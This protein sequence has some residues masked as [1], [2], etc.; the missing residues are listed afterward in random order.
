MI[1]PRH[2]GEPFFAEVGDFLGESY[3]R[4]A[5]TKGTE[6][7][8]G[9]LIDLLELPD[10]ARVLDVGCGPG[11]H[12]LALARRGLQVTGVDISPRFLEL[13]RDRANELGLA[14]RIALFD[15]D[16]RT[17]PFESEFDAVIAVCEGAFGLMG[18]DDALV[19]RRMME[20]AKPGGRVVLTAINAYADVLLNRPEA[21]LD[22]DLGVMHERTVVTSP[23]GERKEVDLWTSVYT[24]RELRLMAIGVGLDPEHVWGVDPGDFDRRAP[25]V[26]RAELMLVA[27]RPIERRSA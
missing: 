1:S 3:L 12:A 9:F 10:G 13:A 21:E 26:T 6:Q 20:A 18:K 23:S 22:A 5:F 16:A 27:R 15:C 11:R 19:L 25:D 24:P 17:M 2:P 14:G 4:Y 8:V 7:E